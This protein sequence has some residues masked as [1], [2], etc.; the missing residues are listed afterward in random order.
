M[1]VGIDSTAKGYTGGTV[2]APA[3]A[4]IARKILKVAGGP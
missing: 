4:K 3:F 2:A 1:L